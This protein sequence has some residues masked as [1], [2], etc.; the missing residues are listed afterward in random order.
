MKRFIEGEERGQGTLLPVH[1]D[2]YV[3][4]NN[5]VR[6][7]DVFVEELDLASIVFRRV[8][9][10]KTGR[11]AYHLAVLL[12]LYSTLALSSATFGIFSAH[13]LWLAQM[14]N[15]HPILVVFIRNAAPDFALPDFSH[16]NWK[17][18]LLTKISVIYAPTSRL[19]Y[20]GLQ[21]F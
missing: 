1:L 4:E 8:T 2:D 10:T 15:G 21:C 5:P 19:H 20:L 13:Q 3:T 6:V 16:A 9:P 7:V 12:K 14:E 11:P 17:L 18:P